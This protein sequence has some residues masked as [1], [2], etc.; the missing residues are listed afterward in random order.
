[1]NA[2]RNESKF[3]C[4][5]PNGILNTMRSPIWSLASSFEVQVMTHSLMQNSSTRFFFL[6]AKTFDLS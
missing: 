5:S 6:L 4:Y 2:R 3:C 1:M